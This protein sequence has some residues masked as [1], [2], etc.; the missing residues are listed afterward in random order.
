MPSYCGLKRSIARTDLSTMRSSITLKELCAAFD[1]RDFSSDDLL[2]SDKRQRMSPPCVIEKAKHCNPATAA[3]EAT[4]AL[5]AFDDDAPPFSN[6][7]V[8]GS[9]AHL[10]LKEY[11]LE[12]FTPC[13][14]PGQCLSNVHTVREVT[15][16]MS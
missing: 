8:D 5:D 12:D 3:L 1:V 7:G 11:S 15:R 13:T 4:L 9:L 16:V 6:G 2:R 10:S 14:P